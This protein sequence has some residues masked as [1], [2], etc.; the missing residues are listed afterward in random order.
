[1]ELHIE[2]ALQ[3]GIAAHKEGR[4]QDAE[5]FY[6]TILRAKPEHSHANHNLGVLAVAVG[7]PAEAI[8]F[9]KLALEVGPNIETV[10][11]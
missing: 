7:K 6:R 10:L 9:F 1:M 2:K 8:P 11:A 4:L 3:Q 5:R